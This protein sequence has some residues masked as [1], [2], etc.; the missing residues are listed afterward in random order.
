MLAAITLAPMAVAACNDD[1]RTLRPA[2]PDQTGTVSTTVAA[3]DPAVSDPAFDTVATTTAPTTVL[4]SYL[5]AAPWADAA[6][7]P[8]RH[9]CD[10]D[11]VAPALSWTPAPAGTVEIAITMVDEQNPDFGHWAMSGIAADAIE[12]AEGEV[13]AGAERGLNGRG[14]LG[15]AGPCPPAGET[16]TY[17]ITVHHLAQQLE[18]G[19]GA[20]G[21]DLVL[22]IDAATV[23]T[24]EVSGSYSRT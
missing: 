7:I 3:S 9:T 18:L 17:R 14:E 22:A 12:L 24:A 8:A 15:Y 21:S 10:G 2:G 4:S 19:D 20:E 16:H 23:A 5:V 13:P 11:D 6:P 1:G